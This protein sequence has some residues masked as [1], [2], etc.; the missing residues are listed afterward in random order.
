VVAVVATKRLSPRVFRALAD[1]LWRLKFEGNEFVRGLRAAEQMEKLVPAAEGITV[2]GQIA[3]YQAQMA[4]ELAYVDQL[5]KMVTDSLGPRGGGNQ[6]AVKLLRDLADE[7]GAEVK[8]RIHNVGMFEEA[9]ALKPAI[10]SIKAAIRGRFEGLIRTVKR[11]LQLA[12]PRS[13][14]Q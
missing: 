5:H 13:G 3:E 12:K 10:A 11:R 1:A 9:R 8:P 7:Y 14:T 6:Y 4:R 2:A